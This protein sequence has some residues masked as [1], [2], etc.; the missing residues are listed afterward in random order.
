VIWLVNQSITDLRRFKYIISTCELNVKELSDFT[1]SVTST[2]CSD[3]NIFLFFSSLAVIDISHF[4]LQTPDR[5][6][7][8]LQQHNYSSRVEPSRHCTLD[9]V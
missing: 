6:D 4:T 7:N 3:V 2:C 5:S 1:F 9:C 8:T